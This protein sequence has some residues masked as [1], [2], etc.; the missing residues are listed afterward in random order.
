MAIGAEVV[1]VRGLAKGNT[2]ITTR[3]GHSAGSDVSNG[4]D[5]VREV[6]RRD[7]EARFTP[8]LHHGDLDRLRTAYWAICPQPSPGVDGMTW[9]AYG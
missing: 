7:E 3:P 5:C 4:L 6:A 2:D 1:E 8:L 9:D